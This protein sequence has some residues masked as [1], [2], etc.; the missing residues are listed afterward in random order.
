M[1]L[2]APQFLMPVKIELYSCPISKRMRSVI[3][4][5]SILAALFSAPYVSSFDVSRDGEFAVYSRN[6]QKGRELHLYK[7]EEGKDY[8]LPAEDRN[9][10]SIEIISQGRKLAF[11]S[12]HDGDEKYDVFL[13]DIRWN[14]GHPELL[15]VQNITP[16]TDYTILPGVSFDREAKKMAFVS[17]SEG[18]FASFIFD[19]ESHRAVRATWHKYSDNTAVISPD[20]S[21]LAVSYQKKGQESAIAFSSHSQDIEE[22]ALDGRE[23]D[24]DSPHWMADSRHLLFVCNSFEYSRIGLLD[25]DRGSIEWISSENSDCSCPFSSA[26]GNQI[27]FLT[28]DELGHTPV[29]L[30]R[31]ADMSTRKLEG[32]R[33]YFHPKFAGG[34]MI[35][36][37][38]DCAHISNLCTLFPADGVEWMD[39][40]GSLPLVSEFKPPRAVKY[41]SEYDNMEIGALLYTPAEPHPDKPGIVWIHGGPSWRAYNG[42]DPLLHLLVHSG[43]TVICPDYRGSTGHG[44]KFREANRFVMGIADMAD[45]ASAWSY[46]RDSGI[47]NPSKIAVTGASFGGYLTMCALAFYP[48]RWC[49]GSAIV[50]F[51]NWF[52]EMASEREDLRYWDL[53]NMG[54]PE[55]DRERFIKASPYFHLSSIRAPVQIIAGANDPRC[56]LE[57][58]E[59]TK[60]ALE[61]MGMKPDFIFYPDEGHS[62]QRMENIVDSQMRTFNFLLKHLISN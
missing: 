42:W 29:L 9:Y 35:A 40:G 26:D 30:D 12:D 36:I 13:G 47:A 4:D 3:P 14:E 50:P 17:N 58:S 34:R 18:D 59:Q 43:I 45:C 6:T 32:H 62:F 49:A 16:D 24:A 48:E 10:A 23:L 31:S 41:A 60:E 28:E 52:T 54:D 5:S 56:P 1:L 20:G 38:E 44:R 57:E 39:Q 55:S 61:R 27:L 22:L 21:R 25:T 19:M 33:M 7:F 37:S 15:N 2:P 51:V 8:L 11:L 46:M 53:Q